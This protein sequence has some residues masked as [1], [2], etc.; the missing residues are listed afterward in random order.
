[1]VS[2]QYTI[3][4]VRTVFFAATIQLYHVLY[5]YLILSTSRDR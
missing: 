4:F 1:M 5:Q 2:I 3:R